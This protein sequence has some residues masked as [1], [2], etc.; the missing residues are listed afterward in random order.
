MDLKN[1]LPS[2]MRDTR[3]GDLIAVIQSMILEYKQQNIDRMKTQ[4]DLDKMDETDIENM[5]NYFGYKIYKRDGYTSSLPYLR[6]QAETI[7]P[8]ITH[9]N[10][11]QGYQYVLYCYNFSGDIYP[12]ADNALFLYPYTSIWDIII[13]NPANAILD[14]EGE[15]IL[16]YI[17]GVPIYDQNLPDPALVG[18]TLDGD[19]TYFLD[20]PVSAAL[21]LKRAILVSYDF[22]NVEDSIEGVSTTNTL[23]AFYEDIKRIKKATEVIYFEPRINIKTNIDNSL[24]IKSYYN[25]DRTAQYNIESK[26]INNLY[27]A[28]VTVQFGNGSYA[29]VD[30]TITGVNSLV[31]SYN[32]LNDMILYNSSNIKL[33]VRKRIVEFQK[34]GAISEIALLDLSGNCIYYAKFPLIKWL[35]E[36]YSSYYV[37]IDLV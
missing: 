3:W 33:E 23:T 31:A 6:K 20:V 12:I 7:V 25:Y 1:L 18:D 10:T 36:M 15:N 19:I 26:R 35:P 14:P 29:V 24:T 28:P 11:R 34:L 2:S 21:N 8:R 9:R 5:S 4:W 27:F 30:D 22:L 37:N 13:V 32:I 17:G 16:Y